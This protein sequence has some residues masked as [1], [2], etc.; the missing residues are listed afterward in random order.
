[1]PDK[2]LYVRRRSTDP[3]CDDKEKNM[4]QRSLR[5]RMNIP[6]ADFTDDKKQEFLGDF[7]TISGCPEEEMKNVQFSKGCTNFDVDLDSEAVSRILE[8][9]E[10]REAQ[11]QEMPQDLK[12]FRRFLEKW[13]ATA[14]H[15]YDRISVSARASDEKNVRDDRQLLLIHGWSGNADSFGELPRYLSDHFHCDAK[16]YSYPTNVW[17]KSPSLE[18]IARNLDNWIRNHIH[19]DRVGIVAH[20]MGGVIVR[21]L[22]ASQ[23]GR[24]DP[25]DK[26][27][28]QITFVASP[29]NGAV[30]AGIGS[31]V[32]T[33]NKTQLLDLADDSSFIY[34]LN[35]EWP[36]WMQESVPQHCQ[37]RCIVGLKDDVV[38]PNNARGDDLEAVPILEAG[39]ID[40]VKPKSADDEIVLTIKR[41]LEESSFVDRQQGKKAAS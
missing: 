10:R 12:A 6:F 35:E 18:F 41:F 24:A 23:K 26:L 25:I 5:I 14:M 1:M 29:R 17:A 2:I 27:I 21:R 11:E 36:R 40:I 30:L 34:A 9:F 32:P 3:A 19:A 28:K 15:S 20:S 37:V 8:Y 38:S 22:V 13:S 7:S 4:P 16:I 31:K 39:H 33:L